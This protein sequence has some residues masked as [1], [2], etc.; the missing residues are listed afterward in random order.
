M[1]I[2]DMIVIKNL[3]VKCT[4]LLNSHLTSLFCIK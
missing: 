4:Y 2:I 1:Q 3:V